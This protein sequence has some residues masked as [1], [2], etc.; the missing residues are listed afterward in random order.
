MADCG[1]QLK[2]ARMRLVVRMSTVGDGFETGWSTVELIVV[3]CVKVLG[4]RQD[5]DDTL[6]LK[7]IPGI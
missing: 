5:N 1:G 4:T 2:E 3:S 6:V 7:G